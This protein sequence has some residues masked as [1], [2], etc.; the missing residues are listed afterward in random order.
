MGEWTKTA[1][2]V[3]GWYWMRGPMRD[4]EPVCARLS[5][6]NLYDNEQKKVYRGLKA[7]VEAKWSRTPDTFI[8]RGWQ[9]WSVPIPPPEAPGNEG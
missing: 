2:T 5:M 9:F 8:E 4:D 1:P 7:Q 3:A 6:T